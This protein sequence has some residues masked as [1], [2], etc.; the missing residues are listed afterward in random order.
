MEP[1]H[2]GAH[3]LWLDTVDSTNSELRKRIS[4]FDNLSIIATREQTAGRGQGT[5][6]WYATPGQNLTFSILYRFEG[7]CALAASDALLITQVTT[8]ALRDYLLSRGV[9]AR[10]KWPNDIWVEDRKICGILIENTISEGQ[11]RESIV[12]IGLNLNETGWPAE[13]PNPVSL[14]ELTGQPFDPAAELVALEKEIRRRFGFLASHDGRISLQEEF[15]KFM[16]RLPEGP[17]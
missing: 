12:G 15:G 16:F 7:A 1:S 3:I 17:K 11:V 4:V 2:A 14:R 9:Q 10:I 5:H 6:T 13:L 8:L